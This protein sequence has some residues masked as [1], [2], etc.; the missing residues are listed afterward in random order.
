MVL[1]V[2]SPPNQ[3]E[4][5][6][7]GPAQFGY[8]L[9]T[10]PPVKGQLEIAKPY[11][12]CSPIINLYHVKNKIAIVERGDCMFVDKVKHILLYSSLRCMLMPPQQIS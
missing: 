10:R 2:L 9:K 1:Q 11:K 8:D 6:R 5:Y 12:A 3:N 4:V 7:A